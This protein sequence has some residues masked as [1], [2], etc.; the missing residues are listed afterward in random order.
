[1]SYLTKTHIANVLAGCERLASM[2]SN[3]QFSCLAG[4]QEEI[5]AVV[6]SCLPKTSRKQ[7]QFVPLQV[8]CDFLSLG[9]LRKGLF[10]NGMK[11]PTTCGSEQG[12]KFVRH[13]EK[14]NGLTLSLVAKDAGITAIKGQTCLCEF[15]RYTTWVATGVITRPYK[16]ARRT[17][18]HS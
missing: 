3:V 2:I 17:L 12:L 14:D 11:C 5:A 8:A 9:Y 15:S 1:M 10:D 4:L 6:K 7:W 13:F 18:V 16:R